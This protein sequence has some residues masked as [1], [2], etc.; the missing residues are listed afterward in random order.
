MKLSNH[1]L[2]YKRDAE[3][4]DYFEERSGA[5]NDAT[6]RIQQAVF[7]Q[8]HP[9][10]GDRVIDVGSGNGWLALEL[11]RKGH[12]KPVLIDIGLK[13]LKRF[14][15]LY[16]PVAHCVAADAT[17]LPF[18]DASFSLFVCSEVLEH[19]NEPAIALG[20][21]RRVLSEQGRCVLSTPW[22]ETLR[23]SLCIHC[24]QKTPLNAHI[25]S[26]DET[27]LQLMF[28]TAGFSGIRYRLHGNKL[29]IY[30]R[31]SFFLR[32]LPYSIWRMLDRFCNLF[33]RKCTTIVVR[34]MRR[35]AYT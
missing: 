12:D 31:A 9:V 21:A 23:Y 19:L 20:E 33:F 18:R 27:Q 15:E 7:H 28:E 24:N 4:F 1:T 25:H 2:H 5:D 6:L 10:P 17:L 29:F 34:A 3:L 14:R 16:G 35:T 26:F 30:S 22:R 32:V 11:H 8:A 13:N